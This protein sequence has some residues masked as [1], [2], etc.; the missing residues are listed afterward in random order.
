[1]GEVELDCRESSEE[2][3]IETML[4]SKVD[5]SWSLA[6][7]VGFSWKGRKLDK[8]N[9]LK[10]GLGNQDEQFSKRF[11]KLLDARLVG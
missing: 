5:D 4:K 11:K 3:L 7:R 6:L 8:I 10:D 1:M 9:C 2:P